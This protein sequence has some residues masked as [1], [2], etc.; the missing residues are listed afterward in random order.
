MTTPGP[1]G[2]PGLAGSH[3]ALR[4]DARPPWSP[5]GGRRYWCPA[6]GYL[7]GAALA[8]AAPAHEIPGPARVITRADLGLPDPA[9]HLPACECPRCLLAPFLA[10]RRRPHDR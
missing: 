3:L 7:T 4:I 6:C 9:P 1:P 5:P 2:P 10:A 8:A